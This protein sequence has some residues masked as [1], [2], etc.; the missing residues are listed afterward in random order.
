MT[1]TEKIA[2]ELQT[3]D[4]QIQDV[5]RELRQAAEQMQRRASEALELIEA[6]L[7]GNPTSL[8]WLEFAAGDLR[9]AAEAKV[10]LEKL[11]ERRK[12]L[13][14]LAKTND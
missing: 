6:A 3:A 9:S 12:F 1:T 4:W 7:N 11:V 13:E 10:R 5:L 2:S 8:S 14:H